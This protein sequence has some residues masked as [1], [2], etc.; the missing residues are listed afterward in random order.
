MYE[1]PSKSCPKRECSA[2]SVYAPGVRISWYIP[3]TLD[4]EKYPFIFGEIGVP[5]VF[6]IGNIFKLFKSTQT[7]LLLVPLTDTNF[8]LTCLD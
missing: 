7:G 3:D 2:K 1:V 5:L 4:W 6:A 8:V